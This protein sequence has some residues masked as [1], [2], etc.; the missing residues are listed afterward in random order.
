MTWHH[1]TGIMRNEFC[2]YSLKL[3]G[4]VVIIKFFDEMGFSRGG[5]HTNPGAVPV[6]PRQV[7]RSVGYGKPRGRDSQLR[8]AADCLVRQF[9]H[10]ILRIKPRDLSSQ[11][12]A[13]RAGVETP[14]LSESRFPRHQAAPEL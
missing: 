10:I 1:M 9:K 6:N 11:M 4:N 12:D 5:T 3:S 14:H 7:Q 2:A 8:R 13:E